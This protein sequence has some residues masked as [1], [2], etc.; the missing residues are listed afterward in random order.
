MARLAYSY[1]RVSSDSQTGGDGLDRQAAAFLPFCERHGLQPV[2]DRLLDAGVSAFRGKNRRNG[3]L[4][5]FLRHARDGRVPEGAVLVLEDLDRFSREAASHAERLLLD[6]FDAGLALGV[7]RDDVVVDRA[8]YDSDL[9]IRLQFL[10]RRD[11]AHDYSAKLSGRLASAWSA[12]VERSMTGRKI[13]KLCP[14]WCDW[15]DAAGDFLLNEHV[16]V[17]RR[18]VRMSCEGIGAPRIAQELNAEGLVTASSRA[19]KG[20]KPWTRGY[21]SKVL[22]DR[23]LIGESMVKRQGQPDLILPGYLPAAVTVA[24]FEQSL[25]AMRSRH[26]NFG[27]VGRGDKVRNILQGMT[28]C[29]CGAALSFILRPASRGDS[30]AFLRCT[31]YADG[32]CTMRPRYVPYDEDALL[33][34]LASERWRDYFNRPADNRKRRDLERK[35]REAERLQAEATGKAERSRQNLADLL[36]H[37]LDAGTARELAAAAATIDAAERESARGAALLRAELLSLEGRDGRDLEAEIRRRVDQ[38]LTV[39]R[40]DPVERSRFNSWL[41]LQG[42]RVELVDAARRRFRYGTVELLGRNPLTDEVEVYDTA[43]GVI[44]QTPD[45]RDYWEARAEV[46]REAAREFG[47]AAGG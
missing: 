30:R 18:M 26:G 25:A 17:V 24:E 13:R 32:L 47:S 19:G 38:F 40:H 6:L 37:G 45:G 11:A 28:F 3:A 43:G 12:E 41:M 27:R 20:G 1:A 15:D 7:V 39:G 23:K 4:G 2:P 29:R 14:F 16:E 5:R 31:R 36:G 9:S 33:L 22:L 21:V 10:V 46:L 34:G 42:F 8:A 35:L 44:W